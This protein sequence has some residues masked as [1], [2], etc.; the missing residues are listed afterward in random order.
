MAPGLFSLYFSIKLASIPSGMPDH[1]SKSL[2]PYALAEMMKH[3][4][5]AGNVPVFVYSHG[6]AH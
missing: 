1:Y 5:M 4:F 6:I 3:F 2:G